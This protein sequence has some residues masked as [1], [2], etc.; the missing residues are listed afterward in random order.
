M[1]TTAV[2]AGFLPLR[3]AVP[4]IADRLRAELGAGEVVDLVDSLLENDLPSPSPAGSALDVWDVIG[5]AELITRFDGTRI[6]LDGV[7]DV[8][9]GYEPQF[10]VPGF[11]TLSVVVT[12]LGRV[13]VELAADGAWLEVTGPSI[14]LRI[15]PGWL[16]PVAAGDPAVFAEIEIVE[17]GHLLVDSAGS[18]TF[19]AMRGGNLRFVTAN[20][21]WRIGDTS[22]TLEAGE[23]DVV[24]S[25][26]PE[27]GP[28]VTLTD[29]VLRF[30]EDLAA[31]DGT[32]FALASAGARI[33]ATGFSGTV[34]AMF[35]DT[36]VDDPQRPTTFVGQGAA[37]LFGF[38]FGVS[39]ID[40]E[41]R[42]N[43]PVRC[44]IGGAM[45]LP[46]FSEA[47]TCT[48]GLGEGGDFLV[49]FADVDGDGLVQFTK[50]DV[51]RLALTGFALARTGEV[52][53]LSLSGDIA[54]L[55]APSE[56]PVLPSLTVRNLTISSTGEV[57]LEAGWIE[58]NPAVTLDFIGFLLTIERLGV[59][60]DP[61]L[62]WF[63]VTG[64]LTLVNGLPRATV[65]EL[66]LNLPLP[67]GT[68][69]VTLSGATV[70]AD[71]GGAIQL[72]GG[73]RLLPEEEGVQGFAGDVRLTLAAGFGLDGSLLVGIDTVENYP[74]LYVFI[75]VELPAG[76]PLGPSGVAL[77]GCAGLFG[78]NVAPAR[79]PDESWYDD[80]Y[81]GPPAPGA[82]QSTKWRPERDAFAFGAG[83]TI[84]T[85]DG[86]TI[87]VRALF[88]ITLPSFTIMIEG[89][90]G[91]LTERS[92]LGAD[93]PLRALVIFDPADGILISLEAQYE[94][95][96][97]V[98]FAHGLVEGYFPFHSGAW[99]VYLGE[100]P[101]ERRIVADVLKKLFR[102]DAYVMIDGSQ[103]R[104]GGG[105]GYALD[106]RFGPVAV[107][108]AAGL[109]GAG[110]FSYEPT[111]LEAS[112]ALFGSLR[113]S[114]F[115]FSIGA[116]LDAGITV[117]VPTPFLLSMHFAARLNLCWPLDDVKIEFDV[118]WEE[119][120]PP[121]YPAPLLA[122]CGALYNIS[123]DTI[124]L[125]PGQ[126]AENVP[127]DARFALNFAHAL[128]RP[129][130]GDYP[131]LLNFAETYLHRV[132]PSDTFRYNLA[133]L[134]LERLDDA[135]AVAE[136]LDFDESDS[137][138]FG[139]WQITP[140]GEESG[141]GP[142]PAD[143]TR[144]PGGTLLLFART[145]FEYLQGTWTQNDGTAPPADVPGYEPVPE[146]PPATY[147]IDLCDEIGSPSDPSDGWLPGH[148]ETA[149]GTP[150]PAAPTETITPGGVVIVVH[151][152]PESEGGGLIDPTGG[153]FQVDVEFPGPVVVTGTTV[154]PGPGGDTT[155][156]LDGE[157]A[158]EPQVPGTS[159]EPS[160]PDDGE[161][162]GDGEE[163][164]PE[165]EKPSSFPWWCCCAL[166]LLGFLSIVSAVAAYVYEGFVA[167]VLVVLLAT[168]VMALLFYA[169][170]RARRRKWKRHR[171][172]P[173][174]T[175]LRAMAA[176]AVTR[177]PG[178]LMA[179]RVSFRGTRVSCGSVT[180]VDGAA[181]RSYAQAQDVNAMRAAERAV[182]GAMAYE[183]L[184]D[185]AFILRP[186]SHY[187]LRLSVVK[188]GGANDSV[189]S[190]DTATT[191]LEFRTQPAP[192]SDL[193]PYVL[194]AVPTDLQAPLFRAEETGVR[195]IETY[196]RQMYTRAAGLTLSVRIQ[197]TD[198]AVVP[199]RRTEWRKAEDHVDRTGL[200]AY[201][202][203]V[204]EI[205]EAGISTSSMLRDDI[206]VSLP[207]AP[208]SGVLP[209]G[210]TLEA[211][212]VAS[213]PG[214]PA[215]P[216]YSYR[217][218][219]SR[220]ADAAG[221]AAAMS[222]TAGIYADP[223]LPDTLWTG[224]DPLPISE[225]A[226]L[227]LLKEAL[228]DAPLL[229]RMSRAGKPPVLILTFPEPLPRTRV[230]FVLWVP[231]AESPYPASAH[232]VFRSD[233]LVPLA[234]YSGAP[235]P[236]GRA[237]PVTRL[238]TARNEQP[239]A[240]LATVPGPA[241]AR[242]VPTTTVWAEDGSRAFLVPADPAERVAAGTY[243]IEI[244]YAH[245][246]PDAGGNRVVDTATARVEIP[247]A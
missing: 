94:F 120:I 161:E 69:S 147:D 246:L 68:P 13:H 113:L 143:S 47:V 20:D 213:G 242:E 205:Y 126:I 112:L 57:T 60:F 208:G 15:D 31:K 128:S 178:A 119:Q 198:G 34:S 116:E 144:A 76:I 21:P 71:V 105:I 40:I 110:T 58:L 234:R 1:T 203:R 104:F 24:L 192:P 52:T 91:F 54:I 83:V 167:F 185:D 209:G 114:A 125:T 82:T 218:R 223:G 30:S 50:A 53:T 189:E 122:D 8:L 41:F 38:E 107:R 139:H 79:E 67:G 37:S 44:A 97:N 240:E 188:S 56:L 153:P 217:F 228:P 51:C 75:G 96:A 155:I 33:D 150:D 245:P 165:P 211:A 190:H 149:A 220:Y 121:P 73:F 27:G 4:E 84:G 62:L 238:R 152:F 170:A 108:V 214:A 100:E 210:V 103:T 9:P 23:L 134:R 45:I 236:N 159:A 174:T 10:P 225:E 81:S 135:G 131:R 183:T 221:W 230:E 65:E 64:G 42:S 78:F 237:D 89:R 111:Q 195:F 193:R 5:F 215:E 140:A 199:G 207:E 216:L 169:C 156:T 235:E 106:R 129:A 14:A 2:P 138:L 72:Y 18:V 59:G 231:A 49:A 182:Y 55:R 146:E 197:Y 166:T 86:F 92:K 95:V 133:A 148:G 39:S 19:G 29:A 74:F 17:L 16:R 12:Q 206:L 201:L 158:T 173:A 243:D 184:T 176:A 35:P 226:L 145:P 25:E 151:G 168:V 36:V 239:V 85:Q 162:P 61:A 99:H 102:A 163:E 46:F 28:V 219:T 194:E 187:R 124:A 87:V 196:L 32:G 200:L 80:W 191:D 180:Y 247:V 224:T 137:P 179:D 77:F 98:L 175:A 244:R 229:R 222:A 88:V 118:R 6:I 181:W 204:N 63:G 172:E 11:G 154:D 115:G 93:P 22:V 43:L 160:A 7:L 109:S 157:P 202:T 186:D 66:R 233:Y 3:F 70:D 48:L 232:T 136:T 212:I 90:A 164:E 241:Q 142:A 177:S 127:L 141:G 101:S 132:S 171:R 123:S 117:R 227:P 26:G 130:P